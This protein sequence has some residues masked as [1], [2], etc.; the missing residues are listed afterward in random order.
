MPSVTGGYAFRR[1]RDGGPFWT[2]V[3]WT[4]PLIAATHVPIVLTSGPVIGV[5]TMLVAAVPSAPLTYL[6]ETGGCTVGAPAVLHAPID[7]FKLFLTPATAT[8]MFSLL[9]IA[10]SLTVPLLCL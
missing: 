3:W 8:T 10:V 4:M 6:Y 5:G 2:A 9:L 7:S 1:L